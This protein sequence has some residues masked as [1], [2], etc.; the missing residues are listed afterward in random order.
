MPHKPYLDM[1]LIEFLLIEENAR[2]FALLSPPQREEIIRKV[3]DLSGSRHSSK[4]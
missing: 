2:I 1:T 4:K 3:A